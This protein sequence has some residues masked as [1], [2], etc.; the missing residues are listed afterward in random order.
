ME[1]EDDEDLEEKENVENGGGA[2]R[3]NTVRLLTTALNKAFDIV[4]C[5][6]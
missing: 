4:C 1:E 6:S 3:V 5:W 2:G